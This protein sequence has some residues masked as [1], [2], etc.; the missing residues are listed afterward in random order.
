MY[1]TVFSGCVWT[2]RVPRLPQILLMLLVYPETLIG[3]GELLGSEELL[4]IVW[5]S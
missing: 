3:I 2:L 1:N 4:V 5:G